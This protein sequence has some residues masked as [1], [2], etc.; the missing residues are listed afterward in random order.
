MSQN[1][2]VLVGSATLQSTPVNR[3]GIA[4][5]I[6]DV[7]EAYFDRRQEIHG[8]LD[9]HEVKALTSDQA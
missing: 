1:P 3:V 4:V 5:G 2:V 8:S 7:G 6:E 9:V